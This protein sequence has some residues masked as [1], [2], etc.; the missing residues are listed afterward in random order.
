MCTLR[1]FCVLWVHQFFLKNPSLMLSWMLGMVVWTHAVLGVL[2]ARFI[3]LYLHFFSAVE[4][5]S[6]GKVL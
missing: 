2:Y 3:F 6:H 5:A 1:L 4:R